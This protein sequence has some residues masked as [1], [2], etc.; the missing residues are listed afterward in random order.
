MTLRR[1]SE[2]LSDFAGAGAIFASGLF[3]V[4]AI[5]S[6]VGT[7]GNEETMHNYSI[8]RDIAEDP[9]RVQEI[10]VIPAGESTPDVVVVTAANRG[11]YDYTVQIVVECYDAKHRSLGFSCSVPSL[12]EAG[13]SRKVMVETQHRNA[14]S[15][16]V[17]DIA[18]TPFE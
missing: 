9:I 18:L 2:L 5:R 11:R 1:I 4:L 8:G 10:E 14:E 12:L 15:A 6:L 13:A 3:L 17:A 7:L 16:R